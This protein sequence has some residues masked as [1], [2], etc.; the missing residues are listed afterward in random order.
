MMKPS[1]I[2]CKHSYTICKSLSGMQS[3]EF[4]LTW[5]MEAKYIMLQE[6]DIWLMTDKNVDVDESH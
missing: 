6:L 3:K 1:G 4:A 2:L 5:R